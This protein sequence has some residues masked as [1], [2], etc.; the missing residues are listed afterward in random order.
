MSYK[1][2]LMGIL[3]LL[4]LPAVSSGQEFEAT[5]SGTNYCHSGVGKFKSTVTI[6]LGNNQMLITDDITD[7]DATHTSLVFEDGFLTSSTAGGFSYSQTDGVFVGT[8]NDDISGPTSFT[9]NIVATFSD[10]CTKV[11]TIKAK[12]L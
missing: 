9:G 4:A 1:A 8:F 3:L 7:L 6:V 5:I 2:I 10:G 11:A 12:R